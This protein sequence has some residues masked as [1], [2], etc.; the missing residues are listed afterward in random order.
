MQVLQRVEAR[1]YRF[2]PPDVEIGQC[3]GAGDGIGGIRTGMEEGS[4]AVGR[5]VGIVDSCRA[6]G[7]GER[8]GTARDSLGDT[9][10]VRRDASL[11][12]GKQRS[13]PSP[14]G[15]HL[16]GDQ[17]G[18]VMPSDPLEFDQNRRWVQA[19]AAGAEDQRFD[20]KG[21]DLVIAAEVFKGIERLLFATRSRKGQGVDLEEERPISGVEHATRSRRH[22]ADRIAMVAVL[23]DGDPGA[24]SLL[25]VK[26]AQRHL[27]GH[28]DGG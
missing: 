16:V 6:E 19:H 24:R 10:H 2:V 20:Q 14:A 18:T 28:L 27:Q 23:Q 9:Q 7:R 22:R 15:H 25:V 4:A 5:Q 8:Q 3:R 26:E 11:L 12:A 1:G 17:Q 13:G 21:S